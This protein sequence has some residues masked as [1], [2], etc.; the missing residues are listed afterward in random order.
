MWFGEWWW[1]IVLVMAMVPGL[2]VTEGSEYCHGPGM[3]PHPNVNYDRNGRNSGFPDPKQTLQDQQLEMLMY[4]RLD[5]TN[6]NAKMHFDG[7]D[8]RG[9]PDRYG[10]GPAPVKTPGVTLPRTRI[11][12]ER[13]K[14][15]RAD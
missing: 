3:F 4:K 13:S 8:A 7:P 5:S 14:L 2:P 6:P 12:E 9:N 10:I 15:Q 11:V 1:G